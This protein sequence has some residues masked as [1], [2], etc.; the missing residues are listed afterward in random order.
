MVAEI[1]V[2]SIGNQPKTPPVLL[3][4]KEMPFKLTDQE[5]NYYKSNSP[6]EIFPADISEYY[7]NEIPR[8]QENMEKMPTRHQ[9]RVG[10]NQ[11]FMVNDRRQKIHVST[12]VVPTKRSET[13]LVLLGVY[14]AF[15]ALAA[16]FLF[17]LVLAWLERRS[18]RHRSHLI[19]YEFKESKSLFLYMNPKKGTMKYIA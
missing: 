3:E 1:N 10:D 19:D 13:L 12:E 14:L 15:F 5:Q 17:C 2:N 16:F 6:F 11:R 4:N 8:K 9:F 7:T 18:R